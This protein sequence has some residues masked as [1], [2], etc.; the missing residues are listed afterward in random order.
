MMG[1]FICV[2]GLSNFALADKKVFAPSAEQG[3]WELETKGVYDIDPKK[4][5]NAIQEYRYDVGYGVN[6]FWHTELELEAETLPTEEESITALKATHLEWENIFQLA[7]KGKYWVDPGIYLAYEAPIKNK[8]AGKFEGKI[9]LEKDFQKISNILNISFNKEVGGGASL[10]PDG[11]VSWSTRYRLSRY[12]EPGF[13]Y[14]NEFSPISHHITYQQQSHQVGPCFYGRLFGNVKYNIGYLFGIS[15][16]APRGEV[17]W[18]LEYE[19]H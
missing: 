11:G 15:E 10:H 3:E 18:V 12:L 8:Q 19:F 13:E 16:A 1:V 4:D 9:L 5:K 14:W 2:V 6:S 7:P 17:K